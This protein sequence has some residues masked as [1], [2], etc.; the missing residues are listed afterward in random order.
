MSWIGPA[1]KK[2]VKYGPQAK[3]VWDRAGRPAAEVAARKAQIQLHAGEP[4]HVVLSRGEPVEA[5]PP[6]DI[7]LPTLIKDADLGTAVSSADFEA[8]RVKA[9]LDRVRH[10]DPQ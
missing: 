2:A 9:R 5:F 1:A 3:I 8:K 7:G 10:R 4:V 6:V